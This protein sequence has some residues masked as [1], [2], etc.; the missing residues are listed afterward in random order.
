MDLNRPSIR[1]LKTAVHMALI[2]EVSG[3]PEKAIVA[4]LESTWFCY[5]LEKDRK[6]EYFDLP[7]SG[8]S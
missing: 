8:K 4:K 5:S 7:L 3:K 1:G 2:R 6:T